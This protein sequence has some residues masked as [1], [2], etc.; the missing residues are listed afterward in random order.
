[1]LTWV[2]VMAVSESATGDLLVLAV[3][4]QSSSIDLC[5]FATKTPVVGS[6]KVRGVPRWSFFASGVT[7]RALPV[8]PV[9]IQ[10]DAL[11]VPVMVAWAFA[12]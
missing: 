10:Q 12:T 4:R 1:V 5:G 7:E 9:S 8:L 3:W 6:V 11:P 2:T